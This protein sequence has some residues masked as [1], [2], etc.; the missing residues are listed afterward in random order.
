[1]AAE[2]T[3]FDRVLKILA[4]NYPERFLEVALPGIDVQIIGTLENVELLVPESR[5][6]FVH[7]VLDG[8]TEKLFHLEFQTQYDPNIPLRMFTYSA[9]LT[10]QFRLPVISSVIYLRPIGERARAAYEVRVGDVVVNRFEYLNIHLWQYVDD[11][12]AGRW[13]ELAP[14]LVMLVQDAHREEILQRE[15]ELILREEDERRRGELLAC[16]I[17]IAARYFDRDFLWRFFREEVDVM[18]SVPF[19]EEWLEEKLEEGRR[20]G[21][22]QGLEEGFRKGMVHQLLRLLTYR[23][24]PVPVSVE[25]KL[26]RLS[27][28]Q[29]ENLLQDALDVSSLEEFTERIPDIE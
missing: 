9:L 14:L 4:R 19:I 13:P 25:D 6:D 2:H 12:L 26:Q 24:G 5:V 20:Q 10:R 3:I 27:T 28:A 29:L 18:K 11:I 16:A 17:T 22:Q 1:M 23:F 21:L 15:K 7:R 8:D